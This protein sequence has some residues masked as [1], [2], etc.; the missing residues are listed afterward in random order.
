MK[1]THLTLIVLA[2]LIATP[3]AVEAGASVVRF[4]RN[5]HR[6]DGFHAVGSQASADE[7]SGKLV[8]TDT[9]GRFPDDI[10]RQAPDAARLGG[11]AESHFVHRCESGSLSAVAEIPRDLQ[12]E[13][14]QV[15]GYAGTLFT[16]SG[17][18]PDHRCDQTLTGLHARRVG[19]GVYELAMTSLGDTVGGEGCSQGNIISI[20]ALITIEGEQP[21]VSAH[22]AYQCANKQGV[23]HQVRIFDLT[24]TPADAGFV[25]AQLEPWIVTAPQ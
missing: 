18:E 14:R 3:A 13:W 11:F 23:L 10:I 25:L 1:R 4:A 15:D 21:L 22:T 17:G 24:G 16:Q 6:V 12:S 5:S 20:A 19:P 8:A 9:Q 7:R 2:A